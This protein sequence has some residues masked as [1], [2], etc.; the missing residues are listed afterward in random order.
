MST[1]FCSREKT[2]HLFILKGQS[3]FIC[4]TAACGLKQS[5]GEQQ[6]FLNVLGAI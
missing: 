2:K 5:K 6:L 3:P 1:G 4:F